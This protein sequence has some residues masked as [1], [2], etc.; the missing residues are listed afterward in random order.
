MANHKSAVKRIKQN[1]I[2][3]LRNRIIKTRMKTAIKSL[4]AAHEDKSKDNAVKALNN[5]QSIIDKAAKKGVIHKK[6]ASRKIAR[7]SKLI[8]S[9]SA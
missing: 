5:A 6:N 2:R 8:N 7:L 4:K 3:R 9:I 1:E